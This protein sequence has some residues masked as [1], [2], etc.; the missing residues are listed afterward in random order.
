[1]LSKCQSLM[2]FPWLGLTTLRHHDYTHTNASSPAAQRIM[3]DICKWH[4]EEFAYLLGKLK[5]V[6]EGDGNL[7]DHTLCVFIHE[8]AEADP[9]KDNGL[10]VILA[11]HAGGLKTGMHTKA[12]NTIGD[13][14]LTLAEEVLKTPL[15]KGFPTAQEKMAQIV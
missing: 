11:G 14:Y 6:P 2:R 4:I 15:E 9:H 1:M 13:L 12:H 10:A 3:R 8:H 5:S 7:L